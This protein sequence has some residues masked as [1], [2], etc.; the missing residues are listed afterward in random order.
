MDKLTPNEETMSKMMESLLKTN[1]KKK[2]RS[3]YNRLK[4]F[5]TK[6]YPAFR[7]FVQWMNKNH[8]PN[9]QV[10]KYLES[11]MP[12]LE[13]EGLLEGKVVKDYL[14]FEKREVGHGGKVIDRDFIQL[15]GGKQSEVYLTD[16]RRKIL[17]MYDVQELAPSYTEQAIKEIKTLKLLKGTGL[18]PELHDAWYDSSQKKVC[19][20]MEYIACRH[21]DSKD[22]QLSTLFTYMK[23]PESARLSHKQIKTLVVELVQKLRE[24]G[25]YHKDLHRGNVLVQCNKNAKDVTLKA[26]DFGNCML[27]EDNDELKALGFTKHDGDLYDL[28][29]GFHYPLTA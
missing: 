4:K 19:I 15:H 13:L 29:S 22:P 26:V 10:I 17:K 24:K 14:N 2:L 3:A 7:E 20:L 28:P 25:V 21:K 5:P 8:K 6:L 27:T 1:S 9:L 11:V 16:S 12:D 18:G 23:L